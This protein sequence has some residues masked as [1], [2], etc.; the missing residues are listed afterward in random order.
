MSTPKSKNKHKKNDYEILRDSALEFSQ[1]LISIFEDCSEYNNFLEKS[2]KGKKD[3]IEYLESHKV[4]EEESGRQRYDAEHIDL[5][6]FVQVISDYTDFQNSK[7]NLF[8]SLT[9]YMWNSF[10]KHMFEL[11]RASYKANKNFKKRYVT[12]FVEV[13]SK[14]IENSKTAKGKGSGFINADYVIASKAK[15]DEIHLNH[16]NDVVKH[17]STLTS[18][19]V[20]FDDGKWQTGKGKEIYDWFLEIRARRNLLVHRGQ[21]I[22]KE[23]IDLC[24]S[25]SKSNPILKSRDEI[26]FYYKGNFFQQIRDK[27]KTNKKRNKLTIGDGANCTYGYVV[28]VY[29]TLVSL[30]FHY[31][32]QVIADSIPNEESINCSSIVHEF[33]DSSLKLDNKISLLIARNITQTF[34]SLFEDKKCSERIDPVDRVN[35]LLIYKNLG[36]DNKK[37][38]EQFRSF[39]ILDESNSLEPIFRMALAFIRDD[40]KEGFN[41]LETLP[42]EVVGEV[43]MHQWFIFNG[44]R[45]KKRFKEIYKKKFNKP[46]K[47]HIN[48]S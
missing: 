10:E 9:L 40:F 43:A 5:P 45:N 4:V 15:Q 21:S 14:N 23:Y 35:A 19:H 38:I 3:P 27:E 36:A 8:N 48:F 41:L 18:Y 28:H 30:Y 44:L 24:H 34:F 12:R 13:N 46:F 17:G 39:T 1:D 2:V 7:K 47:S 42:I 29:I 32:S 31:W 26:D 16:I 11:I 25:G 22:D 20:L 33:M 6:E 37:P